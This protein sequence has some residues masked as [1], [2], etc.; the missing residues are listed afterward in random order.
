MDLE[1]NIFMSR[2]CNK[3]GMHDDMMFYMNNAM[4]AK[5]YVCTE[6]DK[7]VLSY[8]FKN[9]INPL[10]N[11]IR[12]ITEIS[13]H[14]NNETYLN[15]LYTYQV[16][17]RTEMYDKC[18]NILKSLKTEYLPANSNNN[19]DMVFFLQMIG[20]YTRYMIECC[21]ENELENRKKET[22][23]A[24]MLALEH[25]DHLDE[26]HI[27]RP[28]LVLNLSAFYYEVLNN[29]N[30]A[31][32]VSLDIL[33]IWSKRGLEANTRTNRTLSHLN[34]NVIFWQEEEKKEFEEPSTTAKT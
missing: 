9:H 19:E 7:T 16:K 23:D 25:A 13:E 24:Y 14:R 27:I 33:S 34:E 22:L 20:D 28:G 3:I 12:I 2:V 15:P 21:P 31:L 1:E 17:M 26:Y 32:R 8:G 4:K 11:A 30:D 29:R 18:V 6:K 10:R 5:K